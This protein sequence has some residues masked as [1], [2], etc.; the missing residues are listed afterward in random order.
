LV[1]IL[2]MLFMNLWVGVVCETFNKESYKLSLNH[3]LHKDTATWIKIQLK[4]Y[5]VKPEKKFGADPSFNRIRNCCINLANHPLFESI[6]ML[7][8][9]LN[10]LCL[11]VVWY[12]MDPSVVWA[13][14]MLNFLFM[15]I[16]T[17]EA[18]IKLIALRSYYFA[19]SWNIFDFIVVIGSIT[20]VLLEVFKIN[21]DIAT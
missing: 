2:C 18:V 6:I 10:T 9:V 7:C 17:V 20:A 1:I 3:L 21:E 16:F 15:F 4:C 14:E 5:S 19:N 12:Q 13:M 8:I 11:A